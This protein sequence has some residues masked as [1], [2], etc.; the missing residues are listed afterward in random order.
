MF[1]I[2]NQNHLGSHFSN[3]LN[4]YTQFAFGI[5]DKAILAD[6]N[7]FVNDSSP[8]ELVN[9]LTLIGQKASLVILHIHFKEVIGNTIPLL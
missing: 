5:K 3:T 1:S 8:D 2:K 6:F 9:K 4:F 7:G